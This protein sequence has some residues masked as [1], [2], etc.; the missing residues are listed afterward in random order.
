MSGSSLAPGHTKR[1]RTSDARRTEKDRTK[2]RRFSKGALDVTE[3]VQL[4]A[5]GKATEDNTQ[6]ATSTQDTSA[7]AREQQ[8]K[9]SRENW[10]LSSPVAGQYSNLDPIITSDE[11]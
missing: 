7:H 10:G 2:R 4:A 8:T 1:S 5:K 11:E 9:F 6:D 3:D